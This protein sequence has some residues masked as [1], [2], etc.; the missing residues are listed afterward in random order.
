MGG[1][2]A[3]DQRPGGGGAGAG[4]KSQRVGWADPEQERPERTRQ[5]QGRDQADRDAVQCEERATAKH[6]VED[7]GPGGAE[8]DANADFVDAL[9]DGVGNQSVEADSGENEREDGEGAEKL[10]GKT[11]LRDRS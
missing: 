6:E 3:G 1:D 5:R 8:S 2:V 7:V 11:W 9:C 4:R 10:A